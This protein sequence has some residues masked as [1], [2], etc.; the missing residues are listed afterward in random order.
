MVTGDRGGGI[1]TTGDVQLSM[2]L[3]KFEKN[4]A[5]TG[6][7]GY[8]GTSST[9]SAA[10]V[11]SG[12]L[13]FVSISA[14]NNIAGRGCATT[15]EYRIKD[16]ALGSS[17]GTPSSSDA[18]CS[19][20]CLQISS[21]VAWERKGST[22]TC[23]LLNQEETQT[24]VEF[25]AAAGYSSGQRC[26]GDGA[27]FFFESP[28]PPGV[29]PVWFCQGHRPILEFSVLPVGMSSLTT[30]SICSGCDLKTAA[31]GT[32]MSS[33]VHVVIRDNREHLIGSDVEHS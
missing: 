28:I 27:S 31:G 5:S 11:A 30:E 13:P 20:L 1:A 19:L 4:M 9:S 18:A 15:V 25:V 21:C 10:G 8:I 2:R 26:Q 7:A 3:D 33:E 22:A 24:N 23:W 12:L 6:A 14:S 16:S 17:D 32:A 29:V